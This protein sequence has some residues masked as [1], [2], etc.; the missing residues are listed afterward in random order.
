[1]GTIDVAAEVEISA[2]PSDI[3]AVMFDPHRSTEWMS[4]VTNVNVIDPHV[5]IGA[6]VEHRGR[7]MGQDISWTTAIETIHFPHVLVLRIDDGPFVG[8]VRYE[9]QRSGAGS[10]VRIRSQG[11]AGTFAFMPASVIAVPLRAAIASDLDRLK[12]LVEAA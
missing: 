3:A 4:A 9:I 6:R 7:I 8:T 2:D 12:S 1:M 11:E 5:A 10:R